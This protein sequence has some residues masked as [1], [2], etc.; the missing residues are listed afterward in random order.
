[1]TFVAKVFDPKK[2]VQDYGDVDSEVKAC[3]EASAVFD[4]SFISVVRVSGAQIEDFFRQLTDRNLKG[5]K[6][7]RIR[8]ALC[9]DT[10]G[11]L[12]SDLTI[13]KESADNFL[14]MSGLGLDLSDLANNFEIKDEDVVV[15]SVQGPD[16]LAA[17]SSITDI[18][19]LKTLPYFG[20]TQQDV[21]G[22]K[23]YVGRLGYTG[24]LGFEIVAS[25]IDGCLL[26]ENLIKHV[27]PAGFVAANCLR[28]EAGFVLFVNEFKLP[29]TA[30]EAGLKAFSDNDLT[31]PRYRLV[32]FRAKI[33]G[34]QKICSKVNDVI[35]PESGSI[36]ITSACHSNIAKGVLGLGYVLFDEAVIG[37]YFFDPTGQY[38]DIQIVNNPF[39]DTNKTRPRISLV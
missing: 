4:F 10:N 2:M 7:G 11:W 17:L 32:S 25:S 35:A 23:C 13:W 12:R 6:E 15:Y 38:K 26:W 21:A 20:F 31:R 30:E 33:V 16:V 8:Y 29:V 36:S 27:K 37:T 9:R 5:L 19:L 34:L 22:V 3:R 18:E 24:E 28:I 14:V 1:M 39:Y